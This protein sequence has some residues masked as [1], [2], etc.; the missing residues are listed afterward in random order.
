MSTDAQLTTQADVIRNET[1]EGA[2]TPLRIGNMFRAM[3]D[4]KKNLD[5]VYASTTLTTNN[6]AVDINPGVTGFTTNFSFYWKANATNTGVV[7]LAVNG[8]SAKSVRKDG[9]TVLASGNVVAGRIY[10]VIYDVVLG[11]FQILIPGSGGGGGATA[12]TDLSDVPNAY[13]GQAAKVVSVKGDETGLEFTTP[14][15]S[16]VASVTG[17][18]VDNTDP[19][20]PVISYPTPGDIGAEVAGTAAVVAGALVD[21]INDATAAHAASAISNSAAGGITATDVQ[22]AINELD[23]EKAP[24]ASPTFTG[25]PAAPTAAGGTNSTQLSTTAFVQQEIGAVNSITKI[26]AYQNF[27]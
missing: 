11:W 15:A 5:E 8:L 25:I 17:D 14:S 9:S 24:I 3:I 13:T 12:F 6:Y 19:A 16:G 4:S 22:T 23:T 26:Y 2:N 1:I 21:H 10:P 27:K 18:G 7:T 20:N